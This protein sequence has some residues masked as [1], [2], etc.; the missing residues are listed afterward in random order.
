M[1][2]K[3][4]NATIASIINRYQVREQAK[5]LLKPSLTPNAAIEI[6]LKAKL[7]LDTVQFIAHALPMIEA[8]SWANETLAGRIDEW[9]N[10]QIQALNSVRTWLKSPNETYRIRANQLA[11]RLGLDVAPAWVAKAAYWS[12]TG[13]IVAADQPEVLPPAFLYGQAVSAAITIAAA[14]PPWPLESDGY[15]HYY[16]EAIRLGLAIAQGQCLQTTLLPLREQ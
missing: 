12:G 2:K 14:V 9:D 3:I 15:E 13:S 6:L 4:P 1:L 11:E 8:I 5:L 16:Q 7:Y 10:K